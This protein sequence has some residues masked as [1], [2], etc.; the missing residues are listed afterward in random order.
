M[1][2]EL[3]RSARRSQS[4]SL[5]SWANFFKFGGLYYPTTTMGGSA[6]GDVAGNVGGFAQGLLYANPAVFTCVMVRSLLFSEARFKWRQLRDGQI[7]D[8]FG[9]AALAKLERPEPGKTTSDLL[10]VAEVYDSLAGNWYGYATRSGIKSLRPDWVGILW[11]SNSDEPSGWDLEAEIAAYIYYP[12]GPNSDSE[13]VTIPPD[14]IAHFMPIPDPLAPW[15]GMSWLTPLVREIMGDKAAID[16]KLKFF[17]QGGTPNMIIKPPMDMGLEEAKQWAGEFQKKY[18]SGIESAYKMMFLVGGA[19]ATVVGTNMQQMDYRSLQGLSETRVAAASGVGAVLAQFSEGLQGSA[20]NAGNYNSAR[21]R[22][23]DAT[24][25]PLWSKFVGAVSNVIDAP[26][27]AELWYDDKHIPFLQEDAADDANIMQMHSAAIRQLV[28]AGYEPSAVVDAITSGNLR[29]LS[30]QHT[31]LFSVQLQ[32]P[33]AGQS[34]SE[35]GP[36]QVPRAKL[37]ALQFPAIDVPE[38]EITLEAEFE[39]AGLL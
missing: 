29:V 14:R 18:G 30:D 38:D 32:E 19:D 39:A 4:I 36:A 5:D 16:H 33:V 7:G 13:P 20:L 21:R 2:G 27:G 35:Q 12:G 28:D 24:M 1:L 8:L 17:E 10:S 15:R 9:T 25:R 26:P 34:N 22:V 3:I 11:G 37:P 31:G 6:E 23:A